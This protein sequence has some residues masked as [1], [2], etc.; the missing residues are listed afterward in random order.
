[1]SQARKNITESNSAMP[2]YDASLYVDSMVGRFF[3]SHLRARAIDAAKVNPVLIL[4]SV[5]K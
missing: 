1:M 2:H 3:S 4:N 5:R